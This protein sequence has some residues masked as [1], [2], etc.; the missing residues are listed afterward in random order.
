[1]GGAKTKNPAI[2][3]LPL[4]LLAD[5]ELV[6]DGG[7]TYAALILLGTRQAL[8]KDLAQA[9]VIFEYRLNRTSTPYQQREEYR[10]GFFA[11]KD[12]LWRAVNTATIA[13]ISDRMA[14]RTS[15]RSRRRRSRSRSQRCEPPRLPPRRVSLLG[16]T[17]ARWRSSAPAAFL[18]GSP[19]RMCL[20]KQLPRNRRVAEVFSKCG[21][22]DRSGQGVNRMFEDGD[23]AEQAP[24][25]LAGT[26]DYEVGT[27]PPG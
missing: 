8:G 15:P 21:L 5:A 20:W 3:Q 9:E 4:D 16:S 17:P 24:A 23:K 12:D 1:M 2:E 14:I 7:I 19:P 25:R 22:L 26:D 27:D 10:R 11:F 18:R 6:V 13:A